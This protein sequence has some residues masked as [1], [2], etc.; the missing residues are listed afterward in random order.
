MDDKPRP[1]GAP[2]GTPMGKGGT[3]PKP[4]AKRAGAEGVFCDAMVFVLGGV[5][6]PW[7]K[8]MGWARPLPLSMAGVGVGVD[9][10]GPDASWLSVLW[11]SANARSMVVVDMVD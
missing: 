1:T 9:E 5:G 3:G 2:P 4:D 6:Y 7:G 11:M 8:L 10:D